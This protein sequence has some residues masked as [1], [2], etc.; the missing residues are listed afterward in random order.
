MQSPPAQNA[1]LIGCSAKELREIKEYLR[2]LEVERH[3]LLQRVAILEQARSL[4][5]A[6][7][8]GDLRRKPVPALRQI[9]HLLFGREVQVPLT[10][11]P[12][13]RRFPA[14]ERRALP[15]VTA[16]A[17]GEKRTVLMEIAEQCEYVS[18]VTLRGCGSQFADAAT[19]VKQIA[20]GPHDYEFLL[21]HVSRPL[22]IV[23][24][25]LIPESSPWFGVFAADDM[26]LNLSM[27]GL[28]EHV[29]QQRGRVVFARTRDGLEPP[30]VADFV[31]SGEVTSDLGVL[32]QQ[33]RQA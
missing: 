17:P 19:S 29:K 14:L 6:R 20:V 7:A 30:L 16:V 4:R 33:V 27:A 23:D 32:L 15:S 9:W 21:R 28:I 10:T 1:N 13:H 31:Q 8:L 3:D 24:S 12:K 18:I 5:L 2:Q 25:R 11:G 26:R 22:L